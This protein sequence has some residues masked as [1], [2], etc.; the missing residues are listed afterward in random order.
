[1]D[2]EISILKININTILNIK[3]NQEKGAI[4]FCGIAPFYILLSS[5]QTSQPC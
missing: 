2:I 5:R 4:P 1:M 3:I